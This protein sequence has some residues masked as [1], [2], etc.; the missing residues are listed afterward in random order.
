MNKT[1]I[2]AIV[3]LGL[4]SAWTNTPSYIIARI[5]EKDL[6]EYD[7]KSLSKALAM[8]EPL[9]KLADSDD[10]PFEDAIAYPNQEFEKGFSLGDL[11]RY[12]FKPWFDGVEEK[13]I[14]I[15]DKFTLLTI[16]GMAQGTIDS[17]R[18]RIDPTFGKSWNLRYYMA[19]ISDIHQPMHNMIRYSTSHP[20]GDDFG[21]LHKIEGEYS[22]LYDL[23]DDAF[24]QYRSLVYPLS[25]TITLDKYVE[26]IMEDYPKSE[27]SKEIKDDSKSNWSKESYK[28]AK[29]FAYTVLEGTTPTD[30]YMDQGKDYV[31]K[32]IALAGYRLSGRI[33]YM[34]DHQKDEFGLK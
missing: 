33:T 16:A 6:E 26:K 28:I 23:F 2:L 9:N 7:P 3:T 34:M 10:Y 13:E 8:L 14:E 27:Y 18:G 25:S 21:K 19:L 11:W 22:N 30:D 24:G 15:H 17:N 1:L 29:D 5:A 4:V 12:E 32:Q 20:D 31:N